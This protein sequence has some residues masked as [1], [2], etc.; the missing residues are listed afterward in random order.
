M[1]A[2]LGKALE[3]LKSPKRWAAVFIV[4]VTLAL[5]PKTVMERMRIAEL[6]EHYFPLI[7]LCGIVSFAVLLVEFADWLR[8]PLKSFRER[9]EHKAVLYSLTPPE[10]RIIADYF[11]QETD[12][13]YFDL[14]DGVAGG[15]RAKGLIYPTSSLSIFPTGTFAYNL[16]PSVRETMRK[17]PAIMQV[18]KVILSRKANVKKS[19]AGEI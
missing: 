8:R 13:Q 10:M 6:R 4:C 16:H 18:F 15:L 7:S 12:T 19:S 1:L 11:E 17:N 5:L 9:R 2:F 14:T 3:W